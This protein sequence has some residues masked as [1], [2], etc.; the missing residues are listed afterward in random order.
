M[1]STKTLYLDHKTLE[2]ILDV[3]YD[4]GCSLG[5]I[6]GIKRSKYEIVNHLVFPEYNVVHYY[7]RLIKD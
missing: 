3:D 7:M 4:N 2:T 5:T 1:T 6:I